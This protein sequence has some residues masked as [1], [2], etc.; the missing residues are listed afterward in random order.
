LQKVVRS[1]VDLRNRLFDPLEPLELSY[2]VNQSTL[3]LLRQQTARAA[4]H[5]QRLERS[6]LEIAGFD[7]RT[8]SDAAQ[9][10]NML[11]SARIDVRVSRIQ[12]E[13][14]ERFL[15]RFEVLRRLLRHHS[16]YETNRWCVRKWR[17]LSEA[18]CQLRG[19]ERFDDLDVSHRIAVIDQII[20]EFS[21]VKARKSLTSLE[22]PA[23][24][25]KQ[26]E[27]AVPRA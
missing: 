15:D 10:Q 4:A 22:P 19:V 24:I 8:S 13:K 2:R 6:V 25:R 16:E 23:R 12:L 1:V 9:I 21:A 20:H 11:A 3:I 17:Q 26:A 5:V 7:G 27:R 14:W 18:Q